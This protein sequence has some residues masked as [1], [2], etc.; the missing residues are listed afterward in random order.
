MKGVQTMSVLSNMQS[1]ITAIQS[2]GDGRKGTADELIAALTVRLITA[3]A[4]LG[5][6]SRMPT[7][8]LIKSV[9]DLARGP[10]PLRVKTGLRIF[11]DGSCTSNGR[12]GAKAGI[13][14]YATRDDVP[15]KA[16]SAPLGSDEPH[17]NQR[18]E[19]QALY[20]GLQFIDEQPSPVA[21]V[22]TDSKYSLDCLQRW[23][24]RWKRDNW[25]KADGKPVLHQDILKPMVALWERLC[26][27]VALH[28]VEAHTG[29]GDALS[30]GNAKADELA[31]MATGNTP[32]AGG[33]IF[34]NS[35]LST[36]ATSGSGAIT[37]GISVEERFN[38]LA[39]RLSTEPK[40]N[41]APRTMLRFDPY[42]TPNILSL[43]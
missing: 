23:S 4:S 3:E 32:T 10:T 27:T 2:W 15:I 37:S 26:K 25:K 29:K 28:H 7:D 16:H 11:T 22:Y 13:G 19:L 31:T 5:H 35:H 34:P 33:S 36:A 43:L 30:L 42:S 8:P 24:A 40:H 17:T 41:D 1:T 21:N 20:H 6:S 12:R 14:V 39:N 9:L 18:A 38:Q